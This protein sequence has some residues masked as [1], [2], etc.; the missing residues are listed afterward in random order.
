MP[1]ETIE[2]SFPA[3]AGA[4]RMG[5]LRRAL[6]PYVDRFSLKEEVDE[7]AQRIRV[8]RTGFSGQLELKPEQVLV[9]LDYSMLIPGPVRRRI[10]EGVAEALRDLAK[11]DASA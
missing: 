8:K 10:T 11:Q 7:A 1:V 2:Q 3:R 4:D 5:Q 6:G 9:T